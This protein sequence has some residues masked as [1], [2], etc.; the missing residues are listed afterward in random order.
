[1]RINITAGE[2]LNAILQELHPGEVFVPFN[3]AMIKGS[4]GNALF[5]PAFMKER[6]RT[7]GVSLA[8]YRKKLA[9]FIDVL[10]KLSDYDEIVLW[11]G[12]EPFCTAN[13]ETV[14]AALVQK[15]YHGK[16]TIHTVDE[17]TGAILSRE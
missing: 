2:C 7:H 8:E 5:S 16:I 11:F 9:P 13:K 10:H 3:E 4:C 17:G 6:A 14:L 1:M 12:Q 15:E